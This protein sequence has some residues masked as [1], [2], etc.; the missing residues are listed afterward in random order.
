MDCCRL[1]CQAYSSGPVPN[2]LLYCQTHVSFLK[3]LP[4]SATSCPALCPHAAAA[5]SVPGLQNLKDSAG[6]QEP[7][8]ITTLVFMWPQQSPCLPQAAFDQGLRCTV[9][10]NLL[11]PAMCAACRGLEEGQA[12]AHPAVVTPIATTHRSATHVTLQCGPQALSGTVWT[13]SRIA[14]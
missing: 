9:P 1:T 3:R 6:R 10:C 14:C 13:N 12:A 11:Q 8:R 2:A 7:A 4:L 5:S